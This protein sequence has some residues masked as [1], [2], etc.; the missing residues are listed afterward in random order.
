M[1]FIKDTQRQGKQN[2]FLYPH[3]RKKDRTIPLKRLQSFWHL[4]C[5]LSRKKTII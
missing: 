1:V 4:Q 3:G 5:L 2:I